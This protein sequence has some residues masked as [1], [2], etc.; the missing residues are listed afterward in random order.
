MNPVVRRILEHPLLGPKVAHHRR[1][2][3]SAGQFAGSARS[4]S[5]CPLTFSQWF[6]RSA[7]AVLAVSIT[8]APQPV[9]A[10]T[11]IRMTVFMIPPRHSMRECKMV[12]TC[13][14]IAGWWI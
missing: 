5:S 11:S 14:E 2:D 9:A 4:S 6:L 3:G 7:F 1:L 8:A 12:G 10:I 13:P